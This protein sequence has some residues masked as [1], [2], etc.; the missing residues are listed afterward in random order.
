MKLSATIL[1]IATLVLPNVTLPANES[2]TYRVI[3]SVSGDESKKNLIESYLSR[4]LRALG[5]V[6]LSNED[7]DYIIS[8]VEVVITSKGGNENG[9]ALSTT[10]SR[11][12]QNDFLSSMFKDDQV[13]YG[14]FWTNDLFFYPE[15]WLQLGSMEDIKSICVDIIA[16]FDTKILQE[17]RKS[18]QKLLDFINEPKK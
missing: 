3:L 4:E 1:L 10:I 7:S 11:R 2:P 8:V 14:M 15:H 13:K 17:R 18:H 12:F 6:V 5:D 9:I 16:D